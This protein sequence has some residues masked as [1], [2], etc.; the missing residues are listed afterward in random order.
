[1][2]EEHWSPTIDKHGKKHK[3]S[4]LNKRDGIEKLNKN[5]DKLVTTNE[6]VLF[7]VIC[8]LFLVTLLLQVLLTAYYAITFKVDPTPVLSITILLWPLVIG[9]ISNG[10][11]IG[12]L[13][14]NSVRVSRAQ[15]ADIYEIAQDYSKKLDL[16]KTPK[17]YIMQYGGVLNAFATRFLFG[18]IIVIFSDI[19]ELA[20]AQGEDAVRFII[21]HELAHVKRK[22]MS[23]RLILFWGLIIPVIGSAYSRACETTCDNIA[24]YLSDKNPVNGLLVLLA[25]KKLYSKVKIDT[26]LQEAEKE[27]GFWSWLSEIR[28]S[29]PNLSTRIRNVSK[30]KKIISGM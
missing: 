25:G 3:I 5:I 18:D 14:Q 17:V 2:G 11:F 7:F 28:S 23:K 9:L 26:F 22:H 6:K 20:Y 27:E 12:Y 15:F 1:M 13:G 29:H 10:I 19:L 8:C 21:A 30:A 16:K 4:Y 24:A